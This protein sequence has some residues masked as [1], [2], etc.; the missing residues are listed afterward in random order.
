LPIYSVYVV[1]AGTAVDAPV[2]SEVGVKINCLINEYWSKDKIVEIP[3]TIFHPVESR[4]K[5]QTTNTK[6]GSFLFFS[7]ELTIVDGQIY[8]ELHNVSFLRGPNNQNTQASSKPNYMPWLESG[9][10]SSST[11]LTR[12]N[13]A[14]LIHQLQ[15]SPDPAKQNPF[16]L[17]KIMTTDKVLDDEPKEALDK[18]VIK[19][20]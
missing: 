13:N 18:K 11:S 3:I 17:N 16:Q 6:R 1:A 4:L 14:K 7:G 5:G 10:P 20:F 9:S 2:I 12:T 8:L 15:K 19:N